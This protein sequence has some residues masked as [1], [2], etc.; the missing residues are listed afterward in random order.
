MNFLGIYLFVII[1]GI[2]QAIGNPINAQLRILVQNPWLA[3][4]VSFTVILFA[5]ILLFI[6]IPKP[7]SNLNLITQLPW[8]APLG[9]LAGAIAFFS[10]LLYIDKIGAA[11]FNG[12]VITANVITSLVLDHYGW[13]NL[14]VQT[15]NL[16]RCLGGCFMVLGVILI[17]KF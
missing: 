4:V 14:P 13:L 2:L 3:S 15:I 8:W 12:L 1:S 7:T 5:C 9:G 6:I 16:Y 10:G 17:A 11:T